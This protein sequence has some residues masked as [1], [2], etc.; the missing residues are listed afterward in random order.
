MP[1][2]SPCPPRAHGPRWQ[3]F[4]TT[5]LVGPSMPDYI[6]QHDA[7]RLQQ[8]LRG[9]GSYEHVYVRARGKH[10]NIE[11]ARPRASARHRGTCNEDW[12]DRV[13]PQLSQ[14]QRAMGDTACDGHSRRGCAGHDRASGSLPRRRLPVDADQSWPLH[15][16]GH[17]GRAPLGPPAFGLN[18]WGTRDLTSA[19]KPA[20][21]CW[22][23]G[24]EVLGCQP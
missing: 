5:Q 13:R 23:L 2:G 19:N 11:T 21:R 9:L 12:D 6:Q 10:L 24:K 3:T 16:P 15:L 1:E 22:E 7:T 20:P 17:Q 18:Y 4:F 8:L 14:P